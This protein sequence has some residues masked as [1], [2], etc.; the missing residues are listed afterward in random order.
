VLSALYA[1]VRAGLHEVTT[2]TVQEVLGRA[3]IGFD[4]FIRDH[5]STWA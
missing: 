3:P 4:Q 1:M 5:R 2:A